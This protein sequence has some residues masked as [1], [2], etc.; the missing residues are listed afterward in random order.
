MVTQLPGDRLD[1]ARRPARASRPARLPAPSRSAGGARRA[2]SGTACG[3]PGDRAAPAHQRSPVVAAALTKASCCPLVLP[4]AR[5]LGPLRLE[6]VLR[7]RLNQQPQK[8]LVRSEQ[9][10]HFLQR[11]SNFASWHGVHSRMTSKSPAYHDPVTSAFCRIFRTR[12]IPARRCCSHLVT[13]YRATPKQAGGAARQFTPGRCTAKAATVGRGR[14]SHQGGRHSPVPVPSDHPMARHC[15]R[16]GAAVALG[17]TIHGRLGS[18][19]RLLALAALGIRFHLL[20][21]NGATRAMLTGI[22]ACMV[23]LPAKLTC[24]VARPCPSSPGRPVCSGV[25]A[26]P[27]EHDQGEWWSSVARLPSLCDPSAARHGCRDRPRGRL[28]A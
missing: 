5:R 7:Y 28:P 8:V 24:A 17:I 20:P 10:L 16:V 9:R 1:L 22:A 26:V 23:N 4:G 3:G 13:L 2:R 25:A 19:G 6:Q 21:F 15:I 14:R 11:R 12:P 27:A 18:A